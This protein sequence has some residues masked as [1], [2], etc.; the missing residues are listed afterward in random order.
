MS[1]NK[2]LFIFCAVV[3]A[4]T[5]GYVYRVY[6]RGILPIFFRPS[7]DIADIISEHTS[8]S[9]AVN[10]TEFPLSLPDGF[11]IE[12]FAKNLKGAR[13]LAFD[14]KG[15]LWVSRTSEGVITML[16]VENGS[17]VSQHDVFTRLKQPHGI[18]FDQLDAETLY[19]AERDAIS[20]VMVYRPDVGS[21][22][23]VNTSTLTDYDRVRLSLALYSSIVPAKIIDLPSVSNQ[24][25]FTK[26]IRFGPDGRLYVSIGST[27]DVCRETDERR[28]TISSLNPDGTDMKL[29][30]RGLRN[31]VFFTWNPS[32]NRMWATEMGRDG[33]GD[34][35]PP[36][37]INIIEEGKNYG[38]PICY[39]K[40]IHDTEFDKN[41]Y[42]RNPCMEP[43][44]TP[45][46][47]DLPA[48]S[49]PLGLAFIPSV[50]GK[51]Y[52]GDLLLAYHGSWNRSE[53]TGYEIVRVRIAED[54]TVEGVE[55]F[56]SG[57]LTKN[58]TSYGRPVDLVFGQDGALYV[59]DDKAGVVYRVRYQPSAVS[60]TPSSPTT[61]VQRACRPTG[62]SGE[63]CADDDVMSACIFKPEFACYKNATCERQP[64]GECGWTVTPQLTQCLQSSRSSS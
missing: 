49:A 9:P 14:G 31:A 63:V 57:W 11:H 54:G 60:E 61:T 64:S 41:T 17:V 33:L 27:C 38:W 24:R 2:I 46:T 19:I 45:S 25:H 58:N 23:N 53:P 5:I 34:D 13:V 39:G 16:D 8:T 1:R 22:P 7:E 40:N 52:A 21:I 42:I 36:D 3:L 47:V 50:W 43:F 37:E 18:T 15:N 12:I 28:G 10:S 26:T 56:I 62:C 48:H 6:L 44:E 20:R 35:M 30:A 29:V 59:S 55:D 51:E 4:F 32:D